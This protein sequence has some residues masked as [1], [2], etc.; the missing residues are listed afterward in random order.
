MRQKV[1]LGLSEFWWVCCQSKLRIN[2]LYHF[3]HSRSAQFSKQNTSTTKYHWTSSSVLE[4]M[5]LHCGRNFS[6]FV[7]LW[8]VWSISISS[9]YV[10]VRNRVVKILGNFNSEF[11]RWERTWFQSAVST[12]LT[13]SNLKT[14]K[15]VSLCFSSSDLHILVRSIDAKTFKWKK[16]KIFVIFWFI[17]GAQ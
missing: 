1:S 12:A 16:K 11:S 13:F 10:V 15:N 7:L 6:Q 4:K 9:S 14:K 2:W 3:F 5:Q 8:N 17:M